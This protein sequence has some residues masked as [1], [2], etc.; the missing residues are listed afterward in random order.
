MI[1]NVKNLSKEFKSENGVINAINNVN[2]QIKSG[3]IFG[4]I[5]PNGAGKSTMLRILS[6][7]LK[8]SSGQVLIAG[9]DL[10]TQ[11][12]EIRKSIGYVGQH[13]GCDANA[14]GRENLI[15]QGR[16]Y[17]MS[18]SESMN[19]TN[20]LVQLFQLDSVCDRK[21]GSYS[22]GQRRRVDLAMGMIHYP[23]ILFLDEP[24]TGLDPQTRIFLWDELNKLRDTGLTIFLTTHYLDEV[25]S[26]CDQIAIIDHGCI[27]AEGTPAELKSQIPSDVPKVG[28]EPSLYDVFFMKTGR[29]LRD[30]FIN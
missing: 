9:Y 13:G 8:P 2:L 14:T 30:N 3:C 24:T 25:D 15:L 17:G 1:I 28:P 5:G 12:N 20:E 16:L 6:T 27:V 23:E 21:S 10:L 26:V 4:F 7:L 11:S 22:G 19:R 18:K 29:P